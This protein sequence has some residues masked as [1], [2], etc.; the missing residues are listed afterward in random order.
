VLERDAETFGF[1]TLK[2]K[3]ASPLVLF[4]DTSSSASFPDNDWQIGVSD[5]VAG[6][7]ASFL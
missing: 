4:D 5:D 7:Q 3:S 2:V 1:E 6:D